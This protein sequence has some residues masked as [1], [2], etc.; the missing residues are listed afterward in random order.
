M[1]RLRGFLAKGDAPLVFTQG[2]AAVHNPGDFYRGQCGVSKRSQRRA[3]LIGGKAAS[4]GDS[5]DI[6]TL[7]YVAY[8]QVFPHAAVNVHQGGSGTVG[9][10]LR[11]SRPMLV[12]PYGWDQP[13][14]AARVQRL[15]VGVMWRELLTRSKKPLRQH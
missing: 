5:P 15:G 8:S 12:V 9:E 11:A 2:S 10:A 3:I 4:E 7:P 6:L 14:N 1:N 13:D